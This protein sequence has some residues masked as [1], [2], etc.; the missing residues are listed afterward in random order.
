MESSLISND[1]EEG[2]IE[3]LLR[4]IEE[5]AG[6]SPLPQAESETDGA[7]SAGKP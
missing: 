5:N 2:I 7:T 1:T 6:L 3:N 4:T